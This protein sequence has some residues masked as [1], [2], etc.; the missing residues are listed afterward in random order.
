MY[1][2]STKPLFTFLSRGCLDPRHCFCSY[3]IYNLRLRMWGL[4]T[5]WQYTM[6]TLLSITSQHYRL[7]GLLS[8]IILFMKFW[9]YKMSHSSVYFPLILFQICYGWQDPRV[10]TL[11]RSAAGC[12]LPHFCPHCPHC[13]L[14]NQ[15]IPNF[16]P[17]L[18][19]SL[20]CAELMSPRGQSWSHAKHSNI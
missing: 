5:G 20:S 18:E 19:D 4:L 3:L 15:E 2:P 9:W 10:K 12:S 13:P 7:P 6:L 11:K 16:S 17:G 14:S 1:F 8:F